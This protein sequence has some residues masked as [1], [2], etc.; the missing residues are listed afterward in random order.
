MCP[1][2]RREGASRTCR[3]GARRSTCSTCA[4]SIADAIMPALRARRPSR[5][6]PRLCRWDSGVLVQFARIEFRSRSRCTAKAFGGIGMPRRRKT[7]L[8]SGGTTRMCGGSQRAGSQRPL[9]P[10]CRRGAIRFAW[11]GSVLTRVTQTVIGDL[12]A[13]ANAKLGIAWN[14]ALGGPGR[15]LVGLVNPSARPLGC[16]V[17]RQLRTDGE[18]PDAG[19]GPA[20]VGPSTGG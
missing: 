6:P 2:A 18:T 3:H 11:A 9:R 1:G 19:K 5:Q 7:G 16:K 17:D 10:A 20:M 12:V 14:Q 8:R 4:S 13:V 15:C